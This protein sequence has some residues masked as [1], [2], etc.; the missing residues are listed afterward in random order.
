MNASIAAL[1]YL[2]AG[3]RDIAAAEDA[4][5][6]DVAVEQL[7][8]EQACCGAVQAVFAVV[9]VAKSVRLVQRAMPRMPSTAVGQFDV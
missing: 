2:A 7:A 9:T 1:A 3:A 4:L 5:V 6:Q 8:I